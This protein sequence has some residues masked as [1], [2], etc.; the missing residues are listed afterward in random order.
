MNDKLWKKWLRQQTNQDICK[1][2]EV[3]IERLIELEEVNF[4]QDDLVDLTGRALDEDE[5]II[6]M[7]YWRDSGENLI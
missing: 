2:A 7:L 3:A 5:R 6:E 1:L 4:Q